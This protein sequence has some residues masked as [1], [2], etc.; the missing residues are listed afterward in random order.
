M[1]E[2]ESQ[3]AE[4]GRTTEVPQGFGVRLSSGAFG[5]DR[6]IRKR[7]K[8]AAVQ[9][10]SAEGQIPRAGSHRAGQRNVPTVS[11]GRAAAHACGASLPRKFAGIRGMGRVPSRKSCSQ[12]NQIKADASVFKVF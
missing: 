2:A 12:S 5:K 3:R 11:D 7:Q 6:R 9:D 10:A 4:E 8:T 1:T